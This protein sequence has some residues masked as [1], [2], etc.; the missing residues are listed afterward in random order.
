MANAPSRA[1]IVCHPER[2]W[3]GHL[4]C[5]A[6]LR[7]L[8]P[9]GLN[10]SS[11]RGNAQTIARPV[12]SAAHIVQVMPKDLRYGRL[13]AVLALGLGKR[14]TAPAMLDNRLGARR[15]A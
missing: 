15:S 12:R 4:R 8:Q 10:P 1:A 5:R 6:R 14:G 3:F 7:P 9:A 13:L 11:L 2:C